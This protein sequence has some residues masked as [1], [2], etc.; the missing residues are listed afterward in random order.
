MLFDGER[1]VRRTK[2]GTFI[3]HNPS[4]VSTLVYDGGRTSMLMFTN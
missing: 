1:E 3:F 4:T 2:E